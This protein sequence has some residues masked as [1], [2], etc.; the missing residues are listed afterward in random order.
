MEGAVVVN[1][2]S[3]GK[4]AVLAAIMVSLASLA[5]YGLRFA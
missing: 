4:A 1:G 3:R 2:F 5:V